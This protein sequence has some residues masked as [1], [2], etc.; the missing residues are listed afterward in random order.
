MPRFLASQRATPVV[1]LLDTGSVAP[2]PT[3][4]SEVRILGVI[5][6][7]VSLPQLDVERA[8]GVERRC[9]PVCAGTS[10]VGLAGAG[11]P[12][13]LREALR[14]GSYHILHYIGH[15]DFT[16]EGEG[17]LL[18]PELDGSATPVNSTML[19]NLLDDQDDLRLVVLNPATAPHDVD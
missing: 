10:A 13:R 4:S 8:R 3:V 16:P 1:R 12:R 17:M 2:P 7:P 19:A 15:S 14:D 6:N 5:A 9:R 11:Q 18:L